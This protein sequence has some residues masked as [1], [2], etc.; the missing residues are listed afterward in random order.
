MSVP[1]E[2]IRKFQNSSFVRMH[3]SAITGFIIGAKVCDFLLF[4]DSKYEA[5]RED[6]EDDFWKKNGSN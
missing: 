2:V 3:L 1:V 4:D 5:V 6:L